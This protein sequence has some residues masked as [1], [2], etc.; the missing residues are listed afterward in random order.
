MLQDL[1]LA[2]WLAELFAGLDVLVCFFLEYVHAADRLR[3][4][5]GNGELRH[6]LDRGIAAV[7]R[8]EDRVGADL[9]AIERDFGGAQRVIRGVVAASYASRIGIDQEQSDAVGIARIPGCP[10]GHDDLFRRRRAKD[11]T[12]GAIDGE[13]VAGF[14]RLGFDVEEVEPCLAFGE[15]KGQLQAAFGEFRE[16]LLFLRFATAVEDE[17]AAKHHGGEVRLQNQA[18]AEPF[19][20]HHDLGGAAADPSILLGECDAQPAE[21]RHLLP[22]VFAV[23]FARPRQLAPRLELVMFADEAVDAVFEE[24]LFFGKR[25]VHFS[26]PVSGDCGQ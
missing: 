15:G 19:H 18:S 4:E 22:V 9:N 3:A 6:T 13:A 24:L 14:L 12:L 16:Q 23:A 10:R 1:E 8:A 17:I 26:N 7:D 2:D 21:L 5:G 11:D 20:D 25:K